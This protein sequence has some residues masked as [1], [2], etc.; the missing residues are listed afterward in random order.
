MAVDERSITVKVMGRTEADLRGAVLFKHA[1]RSTV[2]IPDFSV[3]WMGATCWVEMKYLRK[4]ATLKEINKVEQLVICHQLYVV[5]GGKC[6]VVIYEEEPRQVTVWTPRS[7]FMHLWPKIAGPTDD[8]RRVLGCTPL[9]LQGNMTTLAVSTHAVM[10]AH[11]GLRIP[12]WPFDIVS[13]LV[14]DVTRGC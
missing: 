2:G 4:T 7:L 9:D 12:E 8:G 5:T 10:A 14:K 6:W 3:S 1:D 11:G 13:R